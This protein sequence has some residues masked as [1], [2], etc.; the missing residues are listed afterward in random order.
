MIKM[1]NI[2][3]VQEVVTRTKTNYFIQLSS[4]DLKLFCSVYE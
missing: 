4:C 1:H 3:Y 2:L